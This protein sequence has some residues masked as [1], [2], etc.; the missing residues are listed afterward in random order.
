[1]RVEGA[2]SG[3]GETAAIGVAIG[4]A[5]S[6]ASSAATET[7]TAALAAAAAAATEQA[8][9]GEVLAALDLGTNNCRLLVVRPALGDHDGRGFQVIDAFSRVVRLGQGMGTSGTLAEDAILRTL[10]A[11]AICA[12]K[13]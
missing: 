10:D 9:A 12:A 7:G 4:G 8:G 3:D 2:A 6:A 13:M 5:V 11:L 1:G